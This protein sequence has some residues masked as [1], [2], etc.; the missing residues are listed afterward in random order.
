MMILAQRL[1]R[2]LAE[3]RAE[4][5][6]PLSERASGAGDLQL[7]FAEKKVEEMKR[8]IQN[9]QL[10]P[11]HLRYAELGRAIIDGWSLGS[12]LGAELIEVEKA[13]RAL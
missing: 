8:G 12:R 7:Q 3:L 13:Y 6:Q 4:Q 11:R 10:P 1:D 5:T 9:G 2:L